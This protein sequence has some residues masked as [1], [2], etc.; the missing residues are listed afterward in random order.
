[1][2]F[3]LGTLPDHSTPLGNGVSCSHSATGTSGYEAV[4]LPPHNMLS[5]APLHSCIDT[6]LS[7]FQSWKWHTPILLQ[8]IISI[9]IPNYTF[10]YHLWLWCCH[11]SIPGG[12][13][14]F[15]FWWN[16]SWV[17][18]SHCLCWHYST[19]PATNT[20]QLESLLLHKWSE[21]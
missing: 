19:T 15:P 20:S 7:R 1:M 2:S 8:V 12:N 11:H 14:A 5:S 21:D 17:W 16:H 6:V 3:S 18:D 10:P 9:S 13:G 4:S